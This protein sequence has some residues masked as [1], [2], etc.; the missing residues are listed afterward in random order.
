MKKIL[1][2]WFFKFENRFFSKVV[3]RAL[4]MMIPLILA[5]GLAC[6]LLNLP[7]PV[8]QT[9]LTS[10]PLQWLSDFL[11]FIYQGTFGF[12]S[13]ALVVALS[14]SYAMEFNVSHDY[15]VMYV[16][17]ALAAFGVQ[18]NIGTE[19]F[20]LNSLG[21][22]GCFAAVL[23]AY[24][25]CVAYTALSKVRW[26]T[27]KT[28]TAGMGGICVPA[29]Q[30]FLPML[31]IVAGSSA[32][33]Q[34]LYVI[35]GV[36]GCYAFVNELLLAAFQYVATSNEFLSGL[37]YTASVNFLWFFGLHGSHIFEP[38][39]QESMAFTGETIFSKPFYDVFVAMGGCGTTICV[40]ILLLLFFRKERSGKLAGLASFT[41]IF[42]LNELLTFGLPIILN[43]VLF[44]PFVLTP[45]ICYCISY[46][47]IALGWVPM[48]VNEVEWTIPIGFGGYLATGS[49]RGSVLQM[50][51]IL[52]GIGIYLPFLRLNQRIESIRAKE[53][54]K[55]LIR[56]LQEQEER[57]EKP[58]FLTRGDYIGS[59]SR[60]L[61]LDL[62]H[63]IRNKELYML[64]QPQMR[65][66]GSCIGAE[67]LLRWDHPVYG[68]IYPPLIIYL[69]EEGKIL[70]QLEQHIIEEV[71]SG[72]ARVQERYAGEFK[73]SVNFTVQSLFWNFEEYIADTMEKYGVDSRKL[74]IEITEQDI[75]L[76]T[77]VVVR[78]LNEL[79]KRGHKLLIDDFGM[80]HTSLL[81][82]QS[83][84]FD[85][86]KL[87]GV[88]TRPLLK[89]KT[90]QKI[91]AS[92]VE[93][94]NE[95]GG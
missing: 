52:I 70:P 5:G 79:K 61:L 63:A 76:Q 15:M 83:N 78:K 38:V 19:Y 4:G 3:K 24:T 72:I 6:A 48:I 54:V 58:L 51:C 92:I 9:M 80:G 73:I 77:D 30:T 29:I 91:V 71:V 12:F 56:A 11:N 10:G 84:Y 93:L 16:V 27:L 45:I 32:V 62:K 17:V 36:H 75:L 46:A 42:N 33:N 39:A 41:V 26:L 22:V 2:R 88:I 37:F 59:I 8:Y 64:Y 82:L 28:F 57:I 60:M 20:D 55:V 18:L 40:L 35:A 49:I 47:A 90:N 53:E 13:V 21:T 43:P 65:A 68:M 87:D 85:I 81:Y 25:S 31:I 89:N 1:K 86:V 34:L 67:A 94:G 44:V 66:D 69:A 23:V 50:V 7:I 74:W 14:F 95:L